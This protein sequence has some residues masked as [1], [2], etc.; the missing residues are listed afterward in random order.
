MN[1]KQKK[2]VKDVLDKTYKLKT[3]W[4]QKDSFQTFGDKKLLAEYYNEAI[5]VQLIETLFISKKTS[6]GC[7]LT[8]DMSVK[9]L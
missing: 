2:K 7:V 6:T 5:E 4:P 9:H 3:F 1:Y 8:H